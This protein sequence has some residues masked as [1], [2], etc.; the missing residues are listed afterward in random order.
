[1][2]MVWCGSHP[3]LLL[4]KQEGGAACQSLANWTQNK[5]VDITSIYFS[6]FVLIYYFLQVLNGWILLI[7]I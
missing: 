4:H 1:M 2:V 5:K 6:G 7:F 3:S